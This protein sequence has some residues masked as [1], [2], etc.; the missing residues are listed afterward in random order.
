MNQTLQVILVGSI[1]CWM[2]ARIN[3]MLW[4]IHRW[5]PRPRQASQL[6]M[7]FIILPWIILVD[8]TG[9]LMVDGWSTDAAT[10]LGGGFGI[11]IMMEAALRLLRR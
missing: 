7:V 10:S 4:I 6:L 11:L 9:Q 1:C 5:L 2:V 8:G 3:L